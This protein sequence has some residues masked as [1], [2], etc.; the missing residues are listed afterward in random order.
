MNHGTSVRLVSRGKHHPY[1]IEVMT[2]GWRGCDHAFNGTINQ[3]MPANLR[4]IRQVLINANV[5]Y[6]SVSEPRKDGVMMF[7]AD[8]AT[9][10]VLGDAH[11]FE[12]AVA[13]LV[14]T[15]WLSPDE[16]SQATS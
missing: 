11:D 1:V 4:E 10:F 7:M 9:E 3:T 8:G 6:F 15:G 5:K 16:P 14:G 2:L 13:A 12:A